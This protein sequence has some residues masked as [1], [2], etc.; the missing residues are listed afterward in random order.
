MGDTSN[1]FGASITPDPATA[2]HVELFRQANVITENTDPQYALR[3]DI[4]SV[5]WLVNRGFNLRG[6]NTND[7]PAA[8]FN[9]TSPL[10]PS[11]VTYLG[12]GA[13]DA[14]LAHA[15]AKA[16]AKDQRKPSWIRRL[17]R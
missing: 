14:Y 10:Q 3:T 6:H 2:Q 1:N 12:A 16:Q 9:F 5:N 17:R 11:A 15:R 13:S 8:A 7:S 4:F